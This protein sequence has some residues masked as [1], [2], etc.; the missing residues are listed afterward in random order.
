MLRF[1]TSGE[2]HGMG[3]LAILEGMPAHLRLREDDI[4]YELKLRQGG[5]GRGG[6]QK[7][8]K[9]RVIII[10]GL[11]HGYT[12]GSPIGMHIVNRDF[13]NWRMVMDP[14]LPG[15]GKKRDKKVTN[16]RP[17]HGDLAGLVKYDHL[18]VRNVLERASARSTAA[19]VAIGAI[20]RMFLKE[21]GI[22]IYGHVTEVGGI[23]CETPELSPGEI[24]ARVAK[25][26]LRST[27]PEAD[28]KIMA[29][30]D[31]SKSEGNTLGGIV[32]VVVENVPVGL[33]S[34]VEWDLKLDA[35]LAEA[36]MSV[37]AIKGVEIGMGFD[38][39]RRRGSEV[40]DPIHYD[41]AKK[42]TRTRG[43]YRDRNNAGGI[44]GGM[45]NGM[46]VVVRA[47]MKPLSTL[48]NPIQSVNYDSKEPAVAAIERSD[49]CAVSACEVIVEAV[50]AYTIADAL[51]RRLGGD[52][53]QAMKPRFEQMTGETL[54][55]CLPSPPKNIFLVG[56]M[57]TGKSRIGSDLARL[58]NWGFI[59]TDDEIEA[60]AE[61]KISDIF[62]SDGEPRFRELESGQI[63]E[64]AGRTHRVIATGGGAVLSDENV[65]LMKENGKMICLNASVEEILGRVGEAADRPLLANQATPE[66]IEKML[67]E[68][69]SRYQLADIQIDTNGKSV[70]QI[71]GEILQALQ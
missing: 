44:E 13:E 1:L 58:L 33:G 32:E 53:L 7:I 19:R 37:Q 27:D 48:L 35:K 8:E 22:G 25:S 46:P 4:N 50:V 63:Q 62:A 9:D 47:A 5:Y 43:F 2:S 42:N 69:A 36:V 26:P 49:V 70:E 51:I 15:T 3:L 16:P 6:R 67:S 56:Y 12:L 55:G 30:I 65:S 11:R 31:K 60:A 17:G 57:G 45:T 23:E 68:R 20:C 39:A 71:I 10:S 34:H 41:E 40:H 64:A 24:R 54:G 66:R 52:S 28:K 38:V 29:A 14:F 59:E 61:K 18:D 21:F